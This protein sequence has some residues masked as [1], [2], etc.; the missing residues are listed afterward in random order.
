MV[1]ILSAFRRGSRGTI[2]NDWG[3]GGSES[4]T[5]STES[6]K[7]RYVACRTAESED[8]RG[9]EL[10]VTGKKPKVS[11]GWHRLAWSEF[12]C[13]L[14]SIVKPFT[15]GRGRSAHRARARLAAG[16]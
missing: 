1:A 13:L 3:G 15:I 2:S 16:L 4:V 9:M 6:S 7:D 10:G 11:S 5:H 8:G 12:C 14:V